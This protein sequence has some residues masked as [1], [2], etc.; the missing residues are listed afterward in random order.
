MAAEDE[1]RD[2]LK[3][4]IADVRQAHRRVRE[5]EENVQEPIAIVSMACR[6][7]G[8]VATPEDLWDVVAGGKD[9][10]S[11]FPDDRG[12]D[13]RELYDPD[14]DRA[15]HIYAREGGFLDAAAFDADFFRISPREAHAMDPQQRMLLET[16]WEAFERAGIP[17]DSL[18]GRD[19]GVF[20][21]VIS[22][23]YYV[24]MHQ[25]P[26][27]LEG[28]RLTGTSTGVASG[29]LA[30]VYGLAGPAV[31]VDT[32][33]SSSLVAIHLA[34]QALRLGECS[35]ALAGGVTVMATPVSLIEFSRQRGLAADGR[36]KAFAG[37]ADGT[38]FSE[39]VG[40]V[41]LERLSAAR[42]SGHRV[43][44]VLR[45]S[46]V[47][48]DGASNGLTAPNGPAQ[49]RVIQA[50]LANARLAAADVDA[51][52]AHGTGTRLGDPIEAQALLAAYGQDRP[53]DRPLWIGSVKS[54]I[55]HPQAAA[56]VAGLIKMVQALRHELLPKTLHVDVP[57]PEV[58]WSAGSVELLRE[59]RCWPRGDR[60]R[61]AGVSSFGA[62]GTNVH[63]IVEEAPEPDDPGG[64]P[65][66]RRPTT[67]PLLLSGK[68]EAAVRA[69]AARLLSYLDGMP[70]VSLADVAFTL[71]TA[72]TSFQHRAAVLA[73]DRDAALAGLDALARD[74]P[75]A[76][77]L[78]GVA[79][80]GRTAFLFTGQGAQRVG[81]GRELHAVFGA[82]AD[83]FDEVAEHLDPLLARPLAEV[84][85]TD[86][87][88]RTE[89]AQPALFA[90]EVALFRLVTSWGVRP[91]FLLGHSV[92]E[93]AAA[94]V[95]G[96]LSLADAATLV[97]ARGRLMQ[98]LPS[99]GLMVAVA[100]TED[101]VTP[102]L[103]DRVSIAAIN[104]PTSV[105]LSGDEDAVTAVGERCA[106]W[107]RRVKRLSVSHAFH[108][109]RMDGMID[110]FRRVV[111][112]LAFDRPRI[113]FVSTVT[114][115]L[116]DADVLCDPEYWVQHIRRPVR[117]SAGIAALRAEGVAS[118]VEIGPDGVLTAMVP[119]CLAAPDGA[120]GAA[121]A[122]DVVAVPL[123]R[124][125]TADEAALLTA[126][127]RLQVRGAGLDGAELFAGTGAR[128]VDVP[129][130]A[131]QRERYWVED[132]ARPVAEVPAGVRL[133]DH[134]LLDGVV[135]VAGSAGQVFSSRLSVARQPWLAD[136]VVA[137]SV[138]VP[139]VTLVELA[140]RA[141]E[142]L[143]CE[144]LA[145]L[146]VEAP[147]VL[148]AEGKVQVQLV[149]D[150]RD[151][152]GRR[153]VTVYSR[154]NDAAAWMRHATG[155]LGSGASRP[156]FD[157]WPWPPEG[158]APLDVG[159]LYDGDTGSF[160]FG[161]AFRGL[162]AVWT[163]GEEIFAEV[164]A[165]PEI[166][167][168]AR[169][170]L[171][172]AVLDAAL[173][174]FALLDLSVK[175]GLPLAWIGVTRQARG[176]SRLRVR[177]TP[178]GPDRAAVAIADDRGAPV[179]SIDSLVV[180]PF[181][182]GQLGIVPAAP[183]DSLYELVWT[184]VSAADETRPASI[185][186]VGDPVAIPGA[187]RVVASLSELPEDQTPELI[188]VA[189]PIGATVDGGPGV[190]ARV[191]TCHMLD[192]VQEFLAAPRWASSRLVVLTRGAV[193][194]VPGEASADPAAAAVW[195]LLRSVQS[196]Q[197]GRIVLIDHDLEE[198]SL[199]A[200]ARVISGNRTQ[201]AIRENE[202]LAPRLSKLTHSVSAATK[203][204]NPEGTVLI[205]GGTG[206][207]GGLM[208]RHV[209]SEYGVRHVL[210]L[211]RR[212][213]RA[214]GA[215]ELETD[216]A[217]L[218]ATVT[219]RACDVADRQEL[220][221]AL[222]EIRPAHPLTAVIHTAGVLDDGI[223]EALTPE[224]VQAVFRPK[225]DA[226]CHLHDLTREVD[227][228]AFVLFSS[229]SGLFGGPGQGNYSA[230]NAFL[231][232][233]AHLRR[234][235]GLPALS[236]AWGMW[237]S[238]SG[239][240]AHLTD[241]DRRRVHN[242]GMLALQAQDALSLFDAAC[243]TGRATALAVALDL[244]GLCERTGDGSIHPLLRDL[245]G[246]VPVAEPPAA[247]WPD[248]L[249]KLAATEQLTAL[250]DLVR[251]EAA[252][253]L[254][255]SSPAEIDE[256]Q[257][258]WDIG[259]DS[260]TAIELRTRLTAVTGAPLPATLIFD[261]LTPVAVAEFLRTELL[262]AGAEHA[263]GA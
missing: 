205:T 209:V 81:M 72:R 244:P 23:D 94:H 139:G 33:C 223:I 202:V 163:R 89:F 114:G 198:V 152:T 253:V 41:L 79:T 98:A 151:G 130:Y 45:G 254:G 143:G 250:V 34:A 4:A 240:T 226:A 102:L 54:N 76:G 118:F 197:P 28:Y 134:P 84:L 232:G 27:D 35:M 248:R 227:L 225:V 3:R 196:E 67:L 176:A 9:V 234:A 208:A 116:A 10:I 37:A 68:S 131:F 125:T 136:H 78:R 90:L 46:A 256:D 101:E 157:G 119:E 57:T 85:T 83:A 121:G 93:I 50:A 186:V 36:C 156:A 166:G 2:Y 65:A 53:A 138:V 153:K 129:T 61:R 260:L 7:P 31:T 168:V 233:L 165:P 135:D 133:I 159:T 38:G 42:R 77:V 48:Q 16:S 104:G 66:S 17:P 237:A 64:P 187:A 115:E 182:P 214:A 167:D 24:L 155:F 221:G 63:L 82:F 1:L 22:H 192:L 145:E 113:P 51:V 70:E 178:A 52:E 112:G 183:R 230:A 96:V 132:T 204:W 146:V 86:Q 170:G 56:G 6:L 147:I 236:V 184:R 95:A 13:T 142:E 235:E 206:T 91:A 120:D 207:L 173:H 238:T 195:G 217:A 100:A 160:T 201:W 219:I 117:F 174:P 32:A 259:F 148:P 108:S 194:V 92:G 247:S 30:Y 12:W 62:S 137:G 213:R 246:A 128:C 25:S 122:P 127:A 261:L 188:I 231:D 171:H 241:D 60:P 14:P 140:L 162:R 211:S 189:A 158:A 239:I 59:P 15:G 179:M 149:V 161:P 218:G 220:A 26:G 200:L 97:A 103:T 18:R 169:Y 8:Q 55:G 228:A 109:P 87:L 20:A 181:S 203:P 258:F 164:V 175:T 215:A 99:E 74:Q 190:A 263:T 199:A 252:D 243:G 110:D 43:L 5:L 229:A 107:G 210:L 126:V 255:H 21:G 245:V 216:L 180:R 257:A 193:A 69:Q 49:Q 212:G 154:A 124:K 58:D 39:G 19:V 224:R 71:A 88:H 111:G 144:V 185:A 106:G 80:G 177:M 150:D 172:P 123:L 222:S 141:G 191:A 40:L 44:A 29:R 11:A 75:A 242:R 105:V 47:N 249:G 251:A 262:P 73:G